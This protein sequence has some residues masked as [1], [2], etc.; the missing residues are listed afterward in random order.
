MKYFLLSPKDQR[1]NTWI[2]FKEEARVRLR[3]RYVDLACTNCKKVDELKAIQ[4]GIDGDVKVSSKDDF[5]L[6]DDGFLLFSVRLLQILNNEG[7]KGFE[8]NAIH[9]TDFPWFFRAFWSSA[10]GRVMRG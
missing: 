1:R 2:I 10:R 6:S 3:D 7:V 8:T 9:L 5:L 4:R